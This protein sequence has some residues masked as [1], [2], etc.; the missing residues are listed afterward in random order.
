VAGVITASE[1]SGI[2]PFTGLSPC[3]FG[4]LLTSLRREGADATRPGRPWPLPLED[5][6]L[7]VAAYWRTNLTLRQPAPLF[8]VS[9]SAADRIIDPLGPQLAL[10]QR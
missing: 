10:K 3:W 6:V 1:P 4:K 5:C 7:L 9:K 2:A 8:G